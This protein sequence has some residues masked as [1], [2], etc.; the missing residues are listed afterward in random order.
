MVRAHA[1]NFSSP[2]LREME[3]TMP[4]PW[5][6]LSPA[7]ITSHFEESIMKG[8]RA[9][10][11]SLARSERKRHHRRGPVDHALVHA[12]VDDVGAVVHL[13][14]RDGDGVLVACPP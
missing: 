5:R 6:H 1:R 7:T 4:L 14:A 9:T 11:G 8:T 2:S 13:L 3:L 10:S 12:D